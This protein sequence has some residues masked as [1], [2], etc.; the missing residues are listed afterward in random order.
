[1]TYEQIEREE[2]LKILQ[3]FLDCHPYSMET[4]VKRELDVAYTAALQRD[5]NYMGICIF[6][7]CRKAAQEIAQ[8]RWEAIQK[9]DREMD[10]R[11]D[12][13]TVMPTMLP[14]EKD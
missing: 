5:L 8:D 3:E 2:A 4:E 11:I 12:K 6:G 1:M 13:I 10:M 7:A 9:D 14:V